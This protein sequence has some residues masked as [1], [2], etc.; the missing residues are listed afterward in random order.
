M[1]KRWQ[2]FWKPIETSKESS[3]KSFLASGASFLG[4]KAAKRVTKARSEVPRHIKIGR[5]TFWQ[6]IIARE[7]RQ[8]KLQEAV[9]VDFAREVSTF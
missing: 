1:A 5:R 8:E 6:S 2:T 4:R 3:F 7:K 9:F